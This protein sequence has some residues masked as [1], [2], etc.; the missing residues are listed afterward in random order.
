MQNVTDIDDPL[1]ERAAAT[2]S[3]GATSPSARPQL[4]RDDMTA[5]GSSPPDHY[6][7]A[8]EA[9]PL[10]V[11]LIGDCGTRGAAYDVDG[12]LYFAVATD[13]RFGDVS[14]LDRD[15][16]LRALRRAGRRPRRAGQA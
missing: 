15:E 6:V 16:M 3:T 10:I 7:G 1:L 5:C 11:E 14:G 4:F 13:A 2:A 12:D 9:I 8:V